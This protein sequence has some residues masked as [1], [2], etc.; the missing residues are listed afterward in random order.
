MREQFF[1][2]PSSYRARNGKRAP[3]LANLVV[4][5]DARRASQPRESP[6]SALSKRP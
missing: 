1:L 5:A 4:D 6:V 3:M 2:D